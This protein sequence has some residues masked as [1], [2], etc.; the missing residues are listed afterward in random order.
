MLAARSAGPTVGC[1]S[2]AA[3]RS[4]SVAMLRSGLYSR[5]TSRFFTHHMPLNIA[6]ELG[7]CGMMLGSRR[8]CYSRAPASRR[9]AVGRTFGGT[10]SP[11]GFSKAN[12]EK[13]YTANLGAAGRAVALVAFLARNEMRALTTLL[14]SLIR[15]AANN[16]KRSGRVTAAQAMA[17]PLGR[18]L[19]LLL[20]RVCLVTIAM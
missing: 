10:W 12:H 8:R 1:A 15:C 20:P 16:S 17:P 13:V 4:T 5:L 9:A 6:I 2:T 14:L 11:T 18:Q 19:G 3:A 7:S